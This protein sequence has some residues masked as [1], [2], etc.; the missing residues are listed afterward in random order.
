V[1]SRAGAAAAVLA[2]SSAVVACGGGAQA[3]EI[4]LDGSPRRANA[5][6]V[7]TDV[8]FE[9]MTLD[10]T[11][12]FDVDPKLRCFDSGNLKSVPLLQRKGTYVQAGVAGHKVS[13]I[14]GYSAVVELPAKPK[15]AFHIGTV[16]S[17][18]AG[19]V[20]FKDGS[21]LKLAPG[22]AALPAGT[23]ARAE[24]DVEHHQVSVLA[25]G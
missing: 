3:P 2:L 14:A 24:I 18:S 5:E 19:E 23:S 1:T 21:V 16:K 7:V 20:V 4:V 11:R 6:G 8:T 22:V 13:W 25:P 9:R 15:L 10:G 12:T 17:A